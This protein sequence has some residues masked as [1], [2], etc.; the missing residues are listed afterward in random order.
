M[1]A[2][3]G[4]VRFATAAD[5]AGL[6]ALLRRC[7]VPGAARVAFTREPSYEAGTGVA[8]ADDATVLFDR[9]GSVVAMGRCSTR[10]VHRNG[11]L[12]RIGYLAELRVDPAERVSG[13]NLR[14]GFGRLAER[15]AQAGAEGFVTCIADDN[16]RGLCCKNREA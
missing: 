5:D 9:D 13:R 14:E 11:V 3:V 16:I 15:A 8:D 10:A 1:T 6:R 2:T 4:A 7:V 12:R